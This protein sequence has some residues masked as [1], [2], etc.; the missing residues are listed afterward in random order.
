[1][2]RGWTLILRG[3]PASGILGML[4]W[5]PQGWL[6]GDAAPPKVEFWALKLKFES[7]IDA[8]ARYS[9]KSLCPGCFFRAKFPVL[10]W[11][12]Q[13]LTQLL[14]PFNSDF[15]NPQSLKG[16]Y[17]HSTEQLRFPLGIIGITKICGIPPSP[18]ISRS[19]WS[20]FLGITTIPSSSIPPHLE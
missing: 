18:D 12:R 3:F 14:F 5:D 17:G 4:L 8:W 1:M 9:Q 13:S 2:V 6:G 16:F 20:R 15:P 10:L 11:D 7:K 19:R